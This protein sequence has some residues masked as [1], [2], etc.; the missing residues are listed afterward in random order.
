MQII[1]MAAKCKVKDQIAEY[2]QRCELMDEED[3]GPEDMPEEQTLWKS[4]NVWDLSRGRSSKIQ[5]EN[6][7]RQSRRNMKQE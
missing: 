7:E 6:T 5:P 4:P 1:R 3:E 2:L